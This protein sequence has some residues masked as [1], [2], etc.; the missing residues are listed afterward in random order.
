M[1]SK[2]KDIIKFIKRDRFEYPAEIFI[3]ESYGIQGDGYYR[4]LVGFIPVSAD[5]WSAE[6]NFIE[7]FYNKIGKLTATLYKTYSNECDGEIKI[8]T[9][10]NYIANI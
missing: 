2:N 3:Y 7:N 4:N 1:K 10:I 8:E 6:E 9:K 5:A